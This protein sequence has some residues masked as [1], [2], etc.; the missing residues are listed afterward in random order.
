MIRLEPRVSTL[1]WF[2]LALP[3]AAIAVTLILCSGLIVMAGASV[4]ESYGVMI[5][6]AFGD[7]YAITETLV[8]AAPMIFTGLAVAVAFRAKFWNIGAEG[9]LLAGAIISCMVGAIEMPGPLAML[10]MAI[11]GF[12]AGSA[13]ALVPAVLRVKLRVDDVVSSLL[14]NS[15]IYYGLMALIEGPWKDSLSGYPI[16]PPIQDSANFPVLWEGTRLHLG[17]IVALV[18]AP[19]IWFLIARTVLG[20]KIQAVGENPEAARYAG[21]N[22][23]RVLLSTAALSG[24]LAGLAG[25]CEVGGVHYQVMAEI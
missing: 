7:D 19:L 23:N 4:I 9:Q 21:I 5:A 22:T 14:L 25:V 17:V 20:F 11:T 10:A 12:V 3:L 24:G 13:I 15:V 2:N 6:A 1:G 8:R 18:M 16:S